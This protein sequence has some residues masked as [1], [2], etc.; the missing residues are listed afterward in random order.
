M[1]FITKQS[2]TNGSL[3]GKQVDK[4]SI[5]LVNNNY[6]IIVASFTDHVYIKITNLINY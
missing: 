1:S 6:E 5:K 4:R 3:L 2:E